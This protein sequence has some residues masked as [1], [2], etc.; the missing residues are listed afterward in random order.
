LPSNPQ[1]RSDLDQLTNS[2]TAAPG[3]P[4][5][6]APAVGAPSVVPAD[7]TQTSALGFSDPSADANAAGA[8]IPPVFPAAPSAPSASDSSTANLESRVATPES[9]SIGAAATK[10]QDQNDNP[11]NMALYGTAHPGF[12][13]RL[14]AMAKGGTNP[15]T[16]QP[17]GGIGNILG[18]IGTAGMLAFG[19]PQQK[20][21]AIE[22]EK[23]TSQLAQIQNEM[24]YRNGMLGLKD[25]SNQNTANKNELQYGAGANGAPLGTSRETADDN[26]QRADVAQQL[27]KSKKLR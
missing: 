5:P 26:A 11:A 23:A 16:G 1:N 10:R 21:L 7:P 8:N 4:A 25:Q 24:Q 3:L 22:Q 19:S 15:D 14:R 17:E 6:L 18:S 12:L 9:L 2:T 27:E 13:D 20:Q